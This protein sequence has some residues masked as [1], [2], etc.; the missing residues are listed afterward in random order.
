M[1]IRKTKVTVESPLSHFAHNVK[2]DRKKRIYMKVLNEAKKEQLEM[3]AEAE[4]MQS[5]QLQAR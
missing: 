1:I 5:Q 2:S 3:I 4:A